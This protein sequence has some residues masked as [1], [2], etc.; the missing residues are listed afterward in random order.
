MKAQVAGKSHMLPIKSVKV[1]SE[2]ERKLCGEYDCSK[3]R[4]VE[5]SF[6]LKPTKGKESQLIG[7]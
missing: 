1:K 7:H 3:S 4:R 2:K 5:I 6:L